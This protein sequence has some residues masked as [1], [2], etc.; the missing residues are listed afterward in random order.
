VDFHHAAKFGQGAIDLAKPVASVKVRH[1]HLPFIAG[2]SDLWSLAV[3]NTWPASKTDKALYLRLRRKLRPILDAKGTHMGV[4]SILEQKYKFGD[5]ILQEMKDAM[6]TKTDASPVPWRQYVDTSESAPGKIGLRFSTYDKD[7]A[8]H[9]T[10][11]ESH[12]LVQYLVGQF[13]ANEN[14][15]QPFNKSRVYPGVIPATGSPGTPLKNR[16]VARISNTAQGSAGIE[17]AR[18]SAKGRG[19]DMPTISLAATTHQQGKLHITPKADES[20]AEGKSKSTQAG[21]VA[22]FFRDLLPEL[23]AAPK[24]DGA[25]AFSAGPGKDTSKFAG[26]DGTF[27]RWVADQGGPDKVAEMIHDAVQATYRKVEAHMSQQL[28]TNMPELEYQYYTGLVEDTP[29]DIGPK[30]DAP[31]TEEQKLFMHALEEIPANARKYNAKGLAD[32]GW[33]TT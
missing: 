32:F 24:P 7:T 11:R 29:H 3:T 12:H 31:E 15:T 25:G 1:I 10:D 2:Q 19:G 9:R 8:Q 33:Y 23:D 13:F 16:Q 5:F 20:P 14:D 26:P 6:S 21:M 22:N 17:V 4:W 27:D 18:T 30:K 28:K